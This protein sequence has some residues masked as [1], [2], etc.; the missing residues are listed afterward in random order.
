MSRPTY[1]R[2]ESALR[3]YSCLTK[4]D[5]IEITYNM[6]TFEF[7][8]MVTV[9]EGEGISVI[10]TDLEVDFET[11]VGYVE[12]ARAPAAPIPTMADKLKI[13]LGGTTAASAG[14]SRPA[15]RASG[16]SLDSGLESFTGVGQSLSGKKVK[17]KGL[18]KKIEEVDPSS[19]INRNA[20]VSCHLGGVELTCSGPRIITPDSLADDGRKVP[21][22]LVLPEGKFFFGFKYTPF[23]PDKA[24]KKA[25]EEEKQGP[26][27]FGGAGNSLKRRRGDVTPQPAVTEVKKEESK[28]DPWAKLGSGNSLRRQQTPPREE[29]PPREPTREEVLAST[30][31][32]ENDFMAEDDDF[33]Y[34]EDVI[35]VDS[36]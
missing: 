11:P 16:G 2:L 35:E 30:Y 21:A 32:D 3:F 13:D 33:D 8:I 26:T 28:P 10:D 18:A 5:I 29:T 7:L 12:P 27:P 22:A 24:P 17:G 9:P 31:L 6:L 20:W 25:D 19:K 4:D 23:D 34:G 14:S 36:D 1:G 15:S